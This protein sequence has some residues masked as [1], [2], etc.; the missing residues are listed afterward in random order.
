MTK[1]LMQIISLDPADS[2]TSSPS[3]FLNLFPARSGLILNCTCIQKLQNPSIVLHVNLLFQVFFRL[4]V[5]HF[6]GL[7]MNTVQLGP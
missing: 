6:F 3:K 7:L 2:T 4:Y 5:F 1:H